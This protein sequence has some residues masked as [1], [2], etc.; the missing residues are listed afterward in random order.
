MICK[1]LID[2]FM[3]PSL[4]ICRSRAAFS[5]SICRIHGHLLVRLNCEC[6]KLPA[7]T[8]HR[9]MRALRPI[10]PT[11]PS[12]LPDRGWHA[13]LEVHFVYMWRLQPS[14]NQTRR[15]R[16]CLGLPPSSSDRYRRELRTSIGLRAAS[17]IPFT[18]GAVAYTDVD[19]PCPNRK[20]ICDVQKLY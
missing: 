16:R 19:P 14:Q 2:L 12:R 15:S 11:H 7:Q 6:N 1:C 4:T 20:Y 5:S 17:R 18:P 8:A 9:S 3:Y 10:L 13:Y